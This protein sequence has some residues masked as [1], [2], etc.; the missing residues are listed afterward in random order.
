MKKNPHSKI[1]LAFLLLILASC[2]TKAQLIGVWSDDSLKNYAIDNVLVMGISREGVVQKLWENTFVSNL[3]KENVKA[4]ASY[5]IGGKTIKLDRASIEKVVRESG[6]STVLISRVVDKASNTQMLG[7]PN[8]RVSGL[9]M[10][11]YF[12]FSHSYTY[13]SA[14]AVTKTLVKVETNFY[15]VATEKLIWTG[16]V[17]VVDPHMTKVDFEMVIGLLIEGLR[18]KN[19]L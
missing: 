13:D 11:D 7:A 9:G 17:D 1:L 4:L 15:D 8:D 12:G 2:T 14:S 6:A 19:L 10:Y 16:Q 18:Q 5:I 3:E